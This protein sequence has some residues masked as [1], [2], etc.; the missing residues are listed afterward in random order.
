VKIGVQQIFQNYGNALPDGRV[1]EEEVALG[2]LA[3]EL[4]YDSIWPVEH[5][6]ED[7]A[8]CPDNLQ[9]L[10]YMA[11]RTKRIHLATGAVI[12][13]WNQPIR[14]AEKLSA[15]DHMSGGRV[16]FGMGRGLARREYLGM[17][18]ELD[19]SRERFDEAADMILKALDTGVIEGNGKFY[20]QA[21]TAI[22]PKP[23]RGFRDRVYCIAMSPDSVD[24]AARIGAGMAIFSQS[25]WPKSAESIN[26]YRDMFRTQHGRTPPI[27]LTCDFVVCDR[28][29]AR[30]EA[31]ARKHIAG[32]LVTVFQHYELMSDH[33]KKAKGYQLYG[34]TVDLLKAIGLDTLAAMYVD[35]Q[36]WG[37]PKQVIDKLLARREII[38]EFRLNCCFR[39]AGIPF[40]AAERSMRVFAEDVM[41][42]LS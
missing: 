9:Y 4:G 14:V 24:A 42:A 21:P 32:Y 28:D 26:R 37:T 12:L 39:F 29:A 30:A 8:A 22:R 35:V 38:G 16:I 10:A 7:Y 13:P 15:L 5:H 34:E 25:E 40:E 41:P 27:P 31:V 20:P 19:S 18:I 1:W 36:A 6:F 3:E 33:F 23:L 2:L 11:A 17:G